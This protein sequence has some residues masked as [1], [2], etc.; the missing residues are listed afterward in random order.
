MKNIKSITC[1]D[2]DQLQPL[3]DVLESLMGEQVEWLSN[4][5][6]SLLGIVARGEGV[7]GW[8][9]AI[10]KRDRE[11]EFHPS[12]VMGN[13]FSQKD[14]R[15]DLLLLMAGIEQFD[16]TDR[17]PKPSQLASAP[18]EMLCVD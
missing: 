15:V 3:H 4:R 5:S 8:N 6:G 12:R 11:G 2:F 13:F 16:D 14:A 10:L 17:G 18:V 1:T 9:Y 7:A